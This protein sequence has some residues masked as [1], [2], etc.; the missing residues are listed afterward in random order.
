MIIPCN[1]NITKLK[2]N[3]TIGITITLQ[4]LLQSTKHALSEYIYI[5]CASTQQLK[6]KKNCCEN[7]RFYYIIDFIFMI[8]K[9]N[10]YNLIQI[11]IFQNILII[12]LK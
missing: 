8:P 6:K 10:P 5:L 9:K 11:D 7:V 12:N 2:N 1:K 3:Y 4:R